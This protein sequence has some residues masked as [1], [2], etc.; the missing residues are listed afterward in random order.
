MK[1]YEVRLRF[2]C[3]LFP[4]SALR[5]HDAI[6]CRFRRGLSVQRIVNRIL[7]AGYRSARPTRCPRLTLDH[8]QCLRVWGIDNAQKA[9]PRHCR[10]R[11][12]CDESRFT[13]FHSDGR[14]RCA[15]VN[16]RDWYM[17]ALNPGAITVPLQ[18]WYGVHH[19]EG[20]ELVVLGGTLNRQRH[21][22]F[23]RDNM[24][25]WA[26]DVFG[27]NFVY[28]QDNATPHT[29]GDTTAFLAQ[30]HVLASSES[31]REPHWACLGPN[32]GLDPRN[33]WPSLGNIVWFHK[34]KI[35]LQYV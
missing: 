35:E 30:Q 33:G 13:L 9:G 5:L 2:N 16:G 3:S 11:V 8:R 1:I 25:P 24:L 14:A 12:F 27:W 4:I 15:T 20:S 28:V 31:R 34:Q 6:I 7:A 32:E 21:I 26:T 10:H 22:R 19:G 23:L 17:H 18:A 29:A